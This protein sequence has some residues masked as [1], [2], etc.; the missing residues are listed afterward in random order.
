MQ[1][2]ASEVEVNTDPDGRM[3]LIATGEK[4]GHGAAVDFRRV[5]LRGISASPLVRACGAKGAL[6]DATAGLGGDAFILA[7]SGFAVTAIERSP[8]VAAVLR[9]GLARACAEPRTA[10]IAQRIELH[11]RDA[12]A[13]IAASRQV[14]AAIYLDP[15]YPVKSA[16]ALASKSIRLVRCA[17]G[18]D[19]DSAVL[20]RAAAES[21]CGRIIVKRPH[22]SQTL[23][24]DPDLVFESKLARYDVYL[25]Q[26]KSLRAPAQK[27]ET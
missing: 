17:V 19:L 9:D 24:P 25:R 5:T 7:A 15:M 27:E 1:R 12:G 21:T 3:E 4:P 20:F 8:L 18:D 6:L 10:A 16:S 23:W 11:E 14:W 26:G 2:A 22:H 13:F